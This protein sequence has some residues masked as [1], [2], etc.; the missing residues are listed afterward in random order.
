MAFR[1]QIHSL[2]IMDYSW[3]INVRVF[4]PAT[5]ESF[6]KLQSI[7]KLYEMASRAKLNLSKFF[8]VPLAL[9][10]IPQWLSNIGCTISNPGEM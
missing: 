6:G 8:I 7:L 1:S 10:V 2:S 3:M 4:I 9:P 5:K